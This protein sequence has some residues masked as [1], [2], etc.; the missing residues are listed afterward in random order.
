MPLTHE[1]L[2]AL[3]PKNMTNNSGSREDLVGI[4]GEIQVWNMN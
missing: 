3:S 4:I 2:N 1:T